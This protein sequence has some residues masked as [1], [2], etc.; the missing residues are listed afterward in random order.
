MLA[1]A[2]GVV[3]CLP[4]SP[5]SPSPEL[6]PGVCLEH[7]GFLLHSLESN[8]SAPT[9][10]LLGKEGTVL[11]CWQDSYWLGADQQKENPALGRERN[12]PLKLLQLACSAASA[13]VCRLTCFFL[14]QS[15]AE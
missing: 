7:S 3:L 1:A 12:E 6:C 9:D 2:A 10:L 13:R 11:A 5:C 15:L 4:G 14:L 8:I